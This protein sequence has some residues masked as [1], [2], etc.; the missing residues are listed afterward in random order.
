[1][2][3]K[4]QL[5]PEG[6]ATALPLLHWPHISNY[7]LLCVVMS[8]DLSCNHSKKITRAWISIWNTCLVG[9]RRKKKLNSP[10]IGL[11][12]WHKGWVPA[13][14]PIYLSLVAAIYRFTLTWPHIIQNIKN[15]Q[16]KNLSNCDK[17]ERTILEHKGWKSE[18]LHF[19]S[20]ATPHTTNTRTALQGSLRH[21]WPTY[22]EMKEVASE[23]H[24]SSCIF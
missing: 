15:Y 24:A 3:I 9:S 12:F 6:R 2:F 8:Y 1:M 23:K 5:C 19:S 20:S 17:L 14:Y 21:R 22:Y 16:N 4:L 18:V 13:Q 11:I 7:R 10:F